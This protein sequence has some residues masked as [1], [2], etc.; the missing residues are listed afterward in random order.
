MEDPESESA[1]FA[2][3]FQ[4][5]LTEQARPWSPSNARLFWLACWGAADTSR[6]YR[7]H[8]ARWREAGAL[9]WASELETAAEALDADWDARIRAQHQAP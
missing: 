8:A 3:L 4:A 7:T 6:A 9:D 1:V 2:S 5:L